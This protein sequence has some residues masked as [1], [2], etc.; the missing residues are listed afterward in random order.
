MD[1]SK[2]FQS[3]RFEARDHTTC[4]TT[5]DLGIRAV[6]HGGMA[7]GISALPTRNRARGQSTV[8]GGLAGY[9]QRKATQY[10]T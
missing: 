3:G 5:E 6:Q 7:L 2:G 10:P 8:K 1:P 9:G 4:G